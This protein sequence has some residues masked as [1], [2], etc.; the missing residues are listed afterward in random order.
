VAGLTLFGVSLAGSAAADPAFTISGQVTSLIGYPAGTAQVESGF[1]DGT[2]WNYSP[3]VDVGANGAF[4][5]DETSGAGEYDLSFTV[6]GFSVPFV[7]SYYGSGLVEP[8]GTVSTNSGVIDDPT[9]TNTAVNV[10]LA[11][12]GY[13]SGTVTSAGIAIAGQEVESFDTITNNEYDANALSDATGFYSIKVPASEPMVIGVESDPTDYFPDIYNNQL[14]LNNHFDMVTVAAGTTTTG[15]DFS[16]VSL[17][18]YIAIAL[19]VETPGATP[20]D[21]VAVDGATAHLYVSDQPDSNPQVA[22]SY[23]DGGEGLVVS[24]SVGDYQLQF[25]NAAGK[26]YAIDSFAFDPTDPSDPSDPNGSSQPA[27][28]CVVDLGEVGVADLGEES[29]VPIEFTLDPDLSICNAAA[30]TPPSP[31]VHRHT[32][33]LGGATTSSTV[34]TPAPTPT[35]TPTP[36]ETPSASPSPSPSATSTPAPLVTSSTGGLPWWVWLLI[37]VGILIIAGI[38]F[39]LFRRR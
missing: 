37:I 39:A 33:S 27:N 17:D 34:S 14:G 16:L 29:P 9:A 4:S 22:T 18:D 24:S 5:L 13:I 6:P 35:P 3:S 10:T 19:E 26:I 11:P 23:I 8:D 21:L 20:P 30:P 25:T 12:A 38:A 2:A 32:F 36:T 31:P 15:I 1:F 28:P 7:D